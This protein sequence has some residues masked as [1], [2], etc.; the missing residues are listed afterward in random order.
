M[1]MDEGTVKAI[2]KGSEASQ[3]TIMSAALIAD[4][5]GART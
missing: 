4:D 3:E 5:T 2:L 1:V